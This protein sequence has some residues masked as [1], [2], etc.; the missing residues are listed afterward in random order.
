LK[1]HLQE[2]M[3][4]GDLGAIQWLLR[5]INTVTLKANEESSEQALGPVE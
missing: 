1:A 2:L 4:R 5:S 3:E